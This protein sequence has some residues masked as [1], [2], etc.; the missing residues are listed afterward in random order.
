MVKYF[1]PMVLFIRFC[2]FGRMNLSPFNLLISNFFIV[3]RLPILPWC[4]AFNST[5]E[6]IKKRKKGTLRKMC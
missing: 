4:F 3:S 2:G 1:G 6:G 5:G